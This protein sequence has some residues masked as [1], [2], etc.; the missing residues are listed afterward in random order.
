MDPTFSPQQKEILGL[1]F[2]LHDGIKEIIFNL[3]FMRLELGFGK[4]PVL[5]SESIFDEIEIGEGPIIFKS[6]DTEEDWDC[7]SKYFRIQ[8]IFLSSLSLFIAL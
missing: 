6:M 8:I 1:F 4:I 7:S 3:S 5:P 2:Q